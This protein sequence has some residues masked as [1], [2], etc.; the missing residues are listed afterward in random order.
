MFNM[1]GVNAKQ[2]LSWHFAISARQQG[3]EAEQAKQQRKKRSKAK[4]V[5]WRQE[6]G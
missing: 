5:G 6:E 2:T 3:A 4:G 1:E